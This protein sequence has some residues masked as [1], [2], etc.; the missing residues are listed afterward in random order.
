MG[1]IETYVYSSSALPSLRF[2]N[3]MGYIETT[4]GNIAFGDYKV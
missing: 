2:N 4:D 3:N 1:Y